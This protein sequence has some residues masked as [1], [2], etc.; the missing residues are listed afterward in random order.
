MKHAHYTLNAL[1]YL[2]LF[3]RT[4]MSDDFSRYRYTHGIIE[5]NLTLTLLNIIKISQCG[6]IYVHFCLV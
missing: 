2:Q 1:T 3:I 6:C 4:M 5:R